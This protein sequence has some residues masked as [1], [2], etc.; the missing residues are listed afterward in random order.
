MQAA[1]IRVGDAVFWGVQYHP[2][3]APGEIAAALRRHADGLVE[4]GLAED[5]DEVEG[6]AALFDRL[7]RDAA[8]R[9]AR[10]RL[11]VGDDIAVEARRRTELTNF[12]TRLVAPTHAARRR[13]PALLET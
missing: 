10:W 5:E 4:A 13:E 7:H 9:S 1:E 2:E 6:Q 8:S 3:L 12:L 11:G